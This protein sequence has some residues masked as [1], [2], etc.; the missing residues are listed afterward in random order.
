VGLAAAALR[1]GDTERLGALFA[2]SQDSM[3]DDYAVSLPEIDALVEIA[4]AHGALASRMTG[5]GFGGCT[6]NLVPEAAWEGFA[7]GVAADYPAHTRRKPV[8]FRCR[9]VDGASLEQ[10][11]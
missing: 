5:G 9:V 8:I 3:R 4:R 10:V 1:A 2:A 11:A 7:R 6:V